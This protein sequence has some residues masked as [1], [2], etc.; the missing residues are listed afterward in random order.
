M[1]I[2]NSTVFYLSILS[3]LFFLGCDYGINVPSTSAPSASSTGSYFPLQGGIL[4][5]PATLE[6]SGGSASGPSLVISGSDTG[7]YAPSTNAIGFAN[8]GVT[9]MVIGSSGDVSMSETA[10]VS[11]VP[12]SSSIQGDLSIGE[13]G[14]SGGAGSFAGNSN[15]TE[16]AINSGPGFIGNLLSVQSSGFGVFEADRYGDV[17]IRTGNNNFYGASLNINTNADATQ[18]IIV[19]GHSVTQSADLQEWQNSV[20]SAVARVDKSGNFVANQLGVGVFSPGYALD[21]E[22]SNATV[23]YFQGSGGNCSITP[24]GGSISCSSDERLKKDIQPIG[25]AL[26]KINQIEGVS[27]LWKKISDPKTRSL[28][29]IAQKLEKVFPE[30]VSE[31]PQGYKQINYANLVPVLSNGIRELYKAVQDQQQRLAA[32]EERETRRRAPAES[33]EERI[34]ALQKQVTK[35]D[36]ENT[37]MKKALCSEKHS[38]EF[39]D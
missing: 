21:V 24:T 27:Y 28:G 15:G 38:L 19:R 3:P 34:K 32:L 11:G 6:P 39:C 12:P 5:G 2:L 35:L 36:A 31:D 22:T 17:S 29:F 26:D 9:S 23:A 20:S 16:L 13:G 33:N 18:G 25:H 30:L 14:F 10:T 7:I 4:Q 1:N 37:M 8:N